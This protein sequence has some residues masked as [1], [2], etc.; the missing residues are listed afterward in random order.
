LGVPAASVNANAAL[1]FGPLR[2]AL[3]PPALYLSLVGD[4]CCILRDCPAKTPRICVI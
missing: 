2:V 3:G 1:R 4:I